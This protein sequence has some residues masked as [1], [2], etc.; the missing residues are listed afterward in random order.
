MRQTSA[1]RS[2]TVKELVSILEHPRSKTLNKH[3]EPQVDREEVRKH[4]RLKW[5]GRY[6]ER[7]TQA[8]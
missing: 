3:R 6:L 8:M 2:N 4:M 5:R 7:Q 1:P